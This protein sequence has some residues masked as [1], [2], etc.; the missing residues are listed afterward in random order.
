MVKED[1]LIY[2][3]DSNDNKVNFDAFPRCCVAAGGE[4]FSYI[5]Q[6]NQESFFC[7]TEPPCIGK[8]VITT[9]EAVVWEIEGVNA[10]PDNI[11]E[12]R[13]NNTPISK[14]DEKCVKQ[15]NEVRFD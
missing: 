12:I 9:G 3:T 2:F 4:Y 1:G 14:Y 13:P 15:S 11:I 5:N 10:V 7:A 6:N 8:P